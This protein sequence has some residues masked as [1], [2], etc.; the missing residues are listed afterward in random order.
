MA[1]QKIKLAVLGLGYVGFPLALEFSKKFNVIGID[2]NT[3]K[4]DSYKA[5]IDPSSEISSH[6]IKKAILENNIIFSN[7]LS[8]LGDVEY[9]IVAVPTPV[10]SDFIPDLSILEAASADIGKNLSKCTTII[11]ESTVYPGATENICIPIIEKYSSMKWKD[12]FNVGYSPERINPGDK[13]HSVRDIVK[14]VS[15]DTDETL[16]KI[17]RLYSSIIDAGVYEAKSIAVAEAAKV[18][19]N[20][21]RDLNIALVNELSIIFDKLGLSTDDVLDAADTKWNFSKYSPGL[22]GG[23]CIGVDPYYLTYIANKNGYD[24]EVILAGRK[25]NEG[26]SLHVAKKAASML[27]GNKIDI[28]QSHILILGASYKENCSDIRNSKIFDLISHLEKF[29]CQISVADQIADIS[30]LSKDESKR[31]INIDTVDEVFDLVILAVPHNDFLADIRYQKLLLEANIVIDIKG[32]YQGK[33]KNK[34]WS[35]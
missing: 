2:Q 27:A 3:H 11:F 25:I 16:I 32:V 14:I 10:S 15:G 30:S 22:V 5:F 9:I 23:H 35:L 20:V 8:N 24:P 21:Q 26:M 12:D 33:T 4:I 17:S 19:E 1:T 28:K 34:Y 18:I 29:G 13:D 31:F 7:D 6:A